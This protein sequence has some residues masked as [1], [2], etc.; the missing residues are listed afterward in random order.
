MIDI[1]ITWMC[2]NPLQAVA[3]LSSFSILVGVLLV[4]GIAELTGHGHPRC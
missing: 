2:H 4:P 3:A 1:V